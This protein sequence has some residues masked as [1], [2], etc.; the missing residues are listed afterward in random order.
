MRTCCLV[1][2][3]AACGKSDEPGAKPAPSPRAGDAAP[4][5]DAAPPID[6]APAPGAKLTVRI[7]DTAYSAD[8]SVVGD[9]LWMPGKTT[10]ITLS[11]KG[12]V[13]C[14]PAKPK[15]Y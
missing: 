1:L 6:A 11:T 15:A 7:K 13:A 8:T 14:P 10:L 4:P 12:G 5:V 2:L 9:A 3:L